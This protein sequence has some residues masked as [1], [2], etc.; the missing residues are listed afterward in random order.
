MTARKHKWVCPSQW[1]IKGLASSEHN[2]CL[3]AKATGLTVQSADNSSKTFLLH[4]QQQGASFPS[5]SE[6]A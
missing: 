6:L 5:A 3:A 2:T 1:A 4:I